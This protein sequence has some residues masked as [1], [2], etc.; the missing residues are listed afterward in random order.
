MLTGTD[1]HDL[2]C[3]TAIIASRQ[4]GPSKNARFC[5]SSWQAPFATS[6]QMTSE[7]REDD[8]MATVERTENGW[9]GGR[10]T[11]RTVEFRDDPDHR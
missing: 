11:A 5:G 6:P 4:F 2:M 3:S 10:W 1:E 9:Q 7:L 8:G